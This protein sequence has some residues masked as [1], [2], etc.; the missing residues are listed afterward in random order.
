MLVS[1]GVIFKL[2]DGTY[3]FPAHL[4]LKS[5]SEMWK[6][7]ADKPVYVG[8]RYICSSAT[9]IFSPSTFALFQCHIGVKL[10][11]KLDLW[12]DGMIVVPRAGRCFVECLVVMDDPLRAIDF[13]A[14]G[15]KGS[16]SD[17]LSLLQ[18]VMTEWIDVVEKHSPGTEYKMTYLSKRHLTEH[19]EQPAAYSAED[20]ENAKTLGPLAVVAHDRTLVEA[21]ADLLV[22]PEPCLTACIHD[23]ETSGPRTNKVFQHQVSRIVLYSY[24]MQ[25]Y[26]ILGESNRCCIVIMHDIQY[27]L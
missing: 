17:C 11:I 12:R 16:E 6:K 10:D 22:D 27:R 25:G 8:R 24:C 1:L 14:R 4:P 2:E 9:S 20:I 21:L 15:G 5:L 26:T 23:A 7:E 19:R 13:V 3:M 18:N